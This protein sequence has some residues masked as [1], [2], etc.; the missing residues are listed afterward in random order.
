MDVTNIETAQGHWVMAK[1]GKRVL[2]PGGRELTVRMIDRLNIGSSDDVVE[3]A[4]GLGITA[5]LV[6]KKRPNSWTGV[7]LDR[8]AASRLEARRTQANLRVVRSNAANTTL[9]DE[10]ADTV[11]CE[12]MLT[13]QSKKQQL[14]I[15]KEAFRILKPGGLFAIHEIALEPASISDDQVAT[16][17]CELRDSLQINARPLRLPEWVALF[18]EAGFTVGDTQTGRMVLLEPGRLLA[19]EGLFR[20]LRIAFNLLTQR[21]LARRMRS[22]RAVFTKY[23]SHMRAIAMILKKA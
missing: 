2:R 21:R 20:V 6:W 3:L 1:A 7:E 23:E 22:M 15:M 11:Y 19:D 8:T 12:A 13:M 17:H 18:Q 4:P 16:I 14:A 9:P 5:A 10:S